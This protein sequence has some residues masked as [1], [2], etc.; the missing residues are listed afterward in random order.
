MSLIN[1]TME[2]IMKTLTVSSALMLCCSSVLSAEKNDNLPDP[3]LTEVWDPIPTIVTPNPVPSDAIVLFDG[4]N[5]SQWQHG[6]GSAVKWNVN[7]GS[8]TVAPKAGGIGSKQKF[9]DMQL[10]LEFKTPAVI[11]GLKG[12]QLGNSGVYL[13]GKYEIQ[14]LNSY[15]NRTYANGQAGAVYKQSAPLVNASLPAQT[16]Q[17]YDI[18]YK[19]PTFNADKS[20]NT[21]AYVTVLHNGVLIQNHTEIQGKTTYRGKPEYANSHGCAPIWL[22]A[23][24]DEVSYRNIWVRKI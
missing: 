12:Q 22:Q 13:Q 15:N 18:I 14:V 4:K 8:M 5:T 3:K 20:V 6:D 7:N 21:K 16:W 19:A 9:C 24:G 17:T 23:H 11:D 1:N 10:H 2:T